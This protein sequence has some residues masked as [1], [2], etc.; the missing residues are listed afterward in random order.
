MYTIGY[1]LTIYV[2]EFVESVKDEFSISKNIQFDTKITKI[3]RVDAELWEKLL[4]A[5]SGWWPYWKKAAI[6]DFQVANWTDLLVGQLNENVGMS[7][8]KAPKFFCLFFTPN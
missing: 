8:T 3:G 6:L 7:W 2:I 1:I 4:F 5:S